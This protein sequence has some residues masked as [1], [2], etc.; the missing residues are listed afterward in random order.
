M[1]WEPQ[2]DGSMTRQTGTRRQPGADW[3]I[4]DMIQ[5]GGSGAYPWLLKTGLCNGTSDR[6]YRCRTRS[7]AQGV[8]SELEAT[9]FIDWSEWKGIVVI[10]TADE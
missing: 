2:T 7:D 9:G 6:L 1:E 8:S 3:P 4:V 5:R 10:D